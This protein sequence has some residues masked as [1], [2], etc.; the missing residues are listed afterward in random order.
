MSGHIRKSVIA[1][2]WYPDIPEILK[3]D[4][5]SYM[6]KASIP[7]IPRKPAVI[8]SPHA[9]YM[10][11]GPVAGYAYKSIS[12]HDYST[13]VVISPSHRAYFPFIS[14]WAR[15]GFETP[16]GIVDVDE[17]LCGKLLKRTKII[18]DDV[19]SHSS[20]HALEIQLPFLQSVLGPFKLCPL[21][22]GQQDFSLC[23]NLAHALAEDVENPDDVLVV[24]SSDLSHF[25]SAKKAEGMDAK[26]AQRIENFDT[27]GL[28]SDL[29]CSES[30]ACGGGPILAAMLYA[31]QIGRTDTKVLNYAHSGHIT[32]D[33]AS[34]VGYL[35]AVIY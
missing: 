8:I 25:H 11:S 23:E 35:S 19:R 30:E 5:V 20:E 18:I 15:G 24:A 22:M 16:L 32:G 14:I 6:D 9:G 1:G 27:A 26:V 31:K 34:V 28:S 4:I 3:Q 2:S 12:G 17:A 7:E 33:N 10:F 21:I 29:E 13:I